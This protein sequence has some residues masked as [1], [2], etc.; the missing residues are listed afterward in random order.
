MAETGRTPEIPEGRRANTVTVVP[1]ETARIRLV[2]THRAAASSGLSEIEAWAHADPPFAEP[3]VPAGNLAANASGQGYPAASA[4]FTA[5]GSAAERVTDGRVAYTRYSSNRWSARGTP[6]ASD[7][8]AVDFGA[9][10][11]VIRV[12]VHFVADGRSLA[13]PRS[14]SVEYWN[15]TAWVPAQVRRRLPAVPEGSAMNTVWVDRVETS[16]VRVVFE[17][18]RPAATAV[19]ELLIWS[20]GT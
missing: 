10:K 6:N 11:A 13:A 16:R 4:S 1:I 5:E 12:E 2:P 3:V 17:H 20:D 14:F 18:A 9:P 8:L 19:T 15:G 7:W